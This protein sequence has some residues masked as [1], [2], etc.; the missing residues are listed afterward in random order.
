MKQFL[1]SVC[2]GAFLLVLAAGCS[3][4]LAQIQSGSQEDLWYKQLKENYS[5]FQAPRTPA[6]AVYNRNAAPVQNITSSPAP[7]PADDPEKAVDRA[8]AGEEI[9][10]VEKEQKAAPAPAPAPEEK[11]P[12]AKADEKKAEAPAPKADEKKEAAPAPAPGND[13]VGKLYTVKAGDS[14]GAIAKQFYGRASMEDV[15]FRANSK[16]LRNRNHL[17]PGMTLVIP[18]L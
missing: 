8:A 14:L 3:P 7:Q 1:T 2:G 12:E 18:E 6:P 16:V 5:S 10:S 15:I 11:A 4:D 17:R 9:A 13:V